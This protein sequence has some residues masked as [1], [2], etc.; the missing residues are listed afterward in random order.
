MIR[1]PLINGLKSK[2]TKEKKDSGVI[3][4]GLSPGEGHGD[5]CEGIENTF[6]EKI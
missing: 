4:W 3:G 1:W 6:P 2:Q 5:S